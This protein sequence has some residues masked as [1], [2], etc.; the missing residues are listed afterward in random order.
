ML[1]AKLP[2]PA[3]SE[4][5]AFAV[6]GAAL[7]PHTTPRA[8]TAAPPSEVTVPPEAAEVWVIAEVVA[9]VTDGKMG[10]VGRVE[11]EPPPPQF[12]NDITS[13]EENSNRQTALARSPTIFPLSFMGGIYRKS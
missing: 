6:V 11:D 3:P 8:V 13:K 2:V 9:R 5:E 4:V 1:L 12:A 7:V 10:A